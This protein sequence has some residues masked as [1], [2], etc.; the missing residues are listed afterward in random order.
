MAPIH[1][2]C[3]TY[4]FAGLYHILPMIWFHFLTRPKSCNLLSSSLSRSHILSLLTLLEPII[5]FLKGGDSKCTQWCNDAFSFVPWPFP[6][7]VFTDR[8]SFFWL[9]LSTLQV[10]SCGTISKSKIS[11]LSSC[12]RKMSFYMWSYVCCTC[13]HCFPL[14]FLEFHLSFHCLFSFRNLLQSCMLSSCLYYSRFTISSLT[15]VSECAS[16]HSVCP[17]F[18]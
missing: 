2:L 17:V 18:I 5:S 15:P 10:S 9:L 8:I 12:E 4:E 14:P 16:V 6:N 13:V 3:T 1:Y 11:P 7:T